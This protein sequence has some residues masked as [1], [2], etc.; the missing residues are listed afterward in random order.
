MVRVRGKIGARTGG[1]EPGPEQDKIEK[2]THSGSDRSR[3]WPLTRGFVH[4]L[5][6]L[7]RTPIGAPCLC[8]SPSASSAPFAALLRSHGPTARQHHLHMALPHDSHFPLVLV[9]CQE[10]DLQMG[11]LV[12]LGFCA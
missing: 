4:L 6:G 5:L 11:S 9:P 2:G 3:N 7:Q 1:T 12:F 10:L 8:P